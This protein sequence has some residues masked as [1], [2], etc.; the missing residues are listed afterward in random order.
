VDRHDRL[1]NAQLYVCFTKDIT[2]P[3][4]LLL[5][6]FKLAG[7]REMYLWVFTDVIVQVCQL[8]GKIVFEWV[9]VSN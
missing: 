4:R 8:R 5:H 9:R 1:L 3:G 2:A 6:T 7:T